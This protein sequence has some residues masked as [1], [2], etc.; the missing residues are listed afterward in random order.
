MISRK[1]FTLLMLL[2]IVFGLLAMHFVSAQ[3][4]TD[5][6]CPEGDATVVVAAGSVG[7]EFEVVSEQAARYMEHCPNITVTL[8]DTPDLATDRLGLYQQFWEAQSPD[9]DVYQVD[10]IW[11]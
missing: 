5:F 6:T 1:S 7:V 2:S 3:D 11:A 10:V 4:G 9:V 8:L